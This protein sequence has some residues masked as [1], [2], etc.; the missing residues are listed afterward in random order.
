MFHVSLRHLT[1]FAIAMTIWI[2]QPIAA[3]IGYAILRMKGIAKYTLL[4]DPPVP[5]R[6]A[7][8][9]MNIR[10]V[11]RRPFFNISL[12]K[13]FLMTYK[14]WTLRAPVFAAG[15]WLGSKLVW[16]L[17]EYNGE[18]AML[19]TK[20]PIMWASGFAALFVKYHHNELMRF[21]RAPL[22]TF[23]AVFTVVWF[24]DNFVLN[25]RGLDAFWNPLHLRLPGPAV[26]LLNGDP[27][28][29]DLIVGPLKY[30]IAT[31]VNSAAITGYSLSRGL[32]TAAE[33][34]T[35]PPTGGADA[36]NS[37]DRA[38]KER[39]I[40]YWEE[41][42][43][44]EQ[45]YLAERNAENDRS[46]H[47]MM[48]SNAELH[49][50]F[51]RS[52]WNVFH[53]FSTNANRLSQNNQGMVLELFSD[54][55]PDVIS[56]TGIAK[57][58]TDTVFGN[59][60]TGIHQSADSNY[61]DT[62]RAQL[63]ANANSSHPKPL[64]IASES[65][66]FATELIGSRQ[67]L[68]HAM[69]DPVGWLLSP[70]VNLLELVTTSTRGRWSP[71]R[72]I[73]AFDD[74]H[75]KVS[76]TYVSMD[77]LRKPTEKAKFEGEDDLPV[78]YDLPVII[79]PEA[80][81]RQAERIQASR[82]YGRALTEHAQFSAAEVEQTVLSAGVSLANATSFIQEAVSPAT[83][84]TSMRQY[85]NMV[86]AGRDEMADTL[87]LR[88]SSDDDFLGTIRSSVRQSSHTAAGDISAEERLQNFVN[89]IGGRDYEEPTEGVRANKLPYSLSS[90]SRNLR[91]MVPITGERTRTQWQAT[92]AAM[93][94]ALE[95]RKDVLTAVVSDAPP[96]ALADL[97]D[98]HASQSSF[99]QNYAASSQA[100][101]A[102][103]LEQRY[104][105]P[106]RKWFQD[107]SKRWTSD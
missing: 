49:D 64:G 62:V 9:N 58:S 93:M 53:W 86:G 98:E 12:R 56:P 47:K 54:R 44:V 10:P 24:A 95:L 76:T 23:G 104:L 51:D 41:K 29:G 55:K 17:E 7:R 14:Y 42:A 81:A 67:L 48:Q 25:K 107:F 79:P 39:N 71:Y 83:S 16:A 60:S 88:N 5:D 90:K 61:V 31:V 21:I 63:Q 77:S 66:F 40:A 59:L 82:P 30:A 37:S 70:I 96:A 89:N 22:Y 38:Q 102:E 69:V 15:T 72:D 50:E 26:A 33:N 78:P 105:A 11:S 4:M 75:E 74:R 101:A 1:A 28:N 8:Y 18:D 100:R 68:E 27:F 6:Y 94:A 32:S 34:A 92:Q 36:S 13:C 57:S 99:R 3:P 43:L 20:K 19:S 80:A 52:A 87:A 103:R 84:T 46:Y 65:G 91:Y 85:A 73:L 106:A 2:A 35:K 97:K 45:G